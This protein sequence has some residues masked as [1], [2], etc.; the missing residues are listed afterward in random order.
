MRVRYCHGLRSCM[1]C[2]AEMTTYAV[3]IQLPICDADTGSQREMEKDS[4]SVLYFILTWEVPSS[5]HP[6]NGVFI[7]GKSVPSQLCL[8]S[9]EFPACH[10]RLLTSCSNQQH[11]AWSIC[12]RTSS[13]ARHISVP[14]RIRGVM[15]L[16]AWFRSKMP[17]WR[18]WLVEFW[19]CNDGADSMGFDNNDILNYIAYCWLITKHWFVYRR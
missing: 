7:I 16:L 11:V 1:R 17:V 12:F 13:T 8:I 3:D 2:E 6:L 19:E 14:L 10:L 5:S 15:G 4:I 9:F 18:R